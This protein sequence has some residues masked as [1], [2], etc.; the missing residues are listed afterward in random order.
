M[1][2]VK[3]SSLTEIED[4]SESKSNFRA[5]QALDARGRHFHYFLADGV[6]PAAFCAQ[7][8]KL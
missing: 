5:E 4:G 8:G 1:M 2:S 7:H 6:E 3:S